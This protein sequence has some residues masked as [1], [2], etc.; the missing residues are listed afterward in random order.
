MMTSHTALA[1]LAQ[2]KTVKQSAAVDQ[3]QNLLNDSASFHKLVDYTRQ[4]HFENKQP[5]ATGLGA[6][7]GGVSAGGAGALAGKKVAPRLARLVP[8]AGKTGL[9]ASRLSRI[10]SKVG[11]PGRLGAALGLVSGGVGGGYAGSSLL[12]RWDARHGRDAAAKSVKKDL[13]KQ[14]MDALRLNAV[15]EASRSGS[16]PLA[17]I[18][19]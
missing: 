19:K 4:K 15:S 17:A 16:T 5:L 7:W 10:A 14:L 18:K 6:V 2:Q 8:K 9:M 12:K 11:K 13:T 1:K 3:I